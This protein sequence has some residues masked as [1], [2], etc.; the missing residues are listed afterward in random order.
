MA[1]KK[2]PVFAR[3]FD[4]LYSINL[5]LYKIYESS[6]LYEIMGSKGIWVPFSKFIDNFTAGPMN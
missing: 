5:W 4:K 1:E 3:M 2:P 6:N